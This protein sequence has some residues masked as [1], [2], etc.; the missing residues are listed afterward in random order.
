MS[1]NQ[2]ILDYYADRLSVLGKVSIKKMFGG[3]GFYMNGRM[4]ALTDGDAIYL[5]AD[6]ENRARFL[7]RKMEQFAPFEDKPEMRMHY[8]SLS[9]EDLED[10][11]ALRELG[12]L[13]IDAATRAA[14]KKK[15]SVTKRAKTKK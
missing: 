15:P 12:K 14:A 2:D 3:A 13:A 6:E 4:F 11:D 8:Y 9:L 10:D 7:S 5:K 1:I